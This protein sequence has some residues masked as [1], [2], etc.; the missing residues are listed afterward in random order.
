MPAPS[1]QGTEERFAWEEAGPRGGDRRCHY[2]GEEKRTGGKRE[3]ADDHNLLH[4]NGAHAA[5]FQLAKFCGLAL[6]PAR[7][8]LELGAV[9]FSVSGALLRR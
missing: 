3:C 1:W 6:P 4:R 9:G 5:R 8:A 7:P 2:A